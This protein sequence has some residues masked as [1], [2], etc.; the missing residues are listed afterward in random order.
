MTTTTH[1]R[2]ATRLQ[3]TG[4]SVRPI[5]ARPGRLGLTLIRFDILVLGFLLTSIGPGGRAA[6]IRPLLR[7]VRRQFLFFGIVRLMFQS[8]P[9]E[10]RRVQATEARLERIYAVAKRGLKG[11]SLAIAAGLLPEEFNQLAQ[12]DPLVNLAAQKGRA[13]AEM[14]LSEVL[15]KAALAGDVKA[16]T[17]ILQHKCDWVAKQQIEVNQTISITAALQEA[18]QRLKYA[19]DDLFSDGRTSL[20]GEVVDARVIE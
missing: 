14:E 18:Q 11:D 13:D 20:N 2:P 8:L 16:A 6:A 19:D 12:L 7:S 1:S 17:T 4:H 5:A 15:Y 3:P 9:Y 10:P